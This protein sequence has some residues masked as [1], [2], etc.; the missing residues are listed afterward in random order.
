MLQDYKQGSEHFIPLVVKS[1]A[2]S[3]RRSSIRSARSGEESSLQL[4]SPACTFM[5]H[6]DALKVFAKMGEVTP[7]RAFC[8]TGLAPSGEAPLDDVYG[9]LDA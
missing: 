6:K 1:L 8:G 5:P 4:S 9:R 7:P 2:S 3:M